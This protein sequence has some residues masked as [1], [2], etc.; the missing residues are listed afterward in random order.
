MMGFLG[1]FE[2]IRNTSS[3]N[4]RKK[5]EQLRSNHNETVHT[6]ADQGINLYSQPVL[7]LT[8]FVE[9]SVDAIRS[10]HRTH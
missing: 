6:V 4:K 10:W 5:E 8:E 3:V 9:M 1:S 2:F 7:T